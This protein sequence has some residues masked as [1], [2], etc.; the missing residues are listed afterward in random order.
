MPYGV[1]HYAQIA[2]C[3]VSLYDLEKIF[4]NVLRLVHFDFQD[5]Y[6]TFT[7]KARSQPIV[8]ERWPFSLCRC[9]QACLLTF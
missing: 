7:L 3:S 8:M 4:F 2:A 9:F 1:M 6:Q 5:Q